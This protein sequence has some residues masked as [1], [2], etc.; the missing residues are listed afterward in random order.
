MAIELRAWHSAM[1]RMRRVLPRPASSVIDFWNSSVSRSP[2]KLPFRYR[3]VMLRTCLRRIDTVSPRGRASAGLLD[4]L[5]LRE[6]RD[7]LLFAGIDV[8]DQRQLGDH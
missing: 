4:R 8:E 3:T 6:A 7:R 2:K 1:F 5:G